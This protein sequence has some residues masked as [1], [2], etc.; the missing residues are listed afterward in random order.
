MAISF[1]R[2]FMFIRTLLSWG[3]IQVGDAFARLV[4]I[5]VLFARHWTCC[6]VLRDLEFAFCCSHLV[7]GA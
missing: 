5:G 2:G 7:A 1:H 6:H 4:S 3:G